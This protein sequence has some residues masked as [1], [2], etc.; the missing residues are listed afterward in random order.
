MPS[1]RPTIVP[2]VVHLVRQLKPRSILDVGIGFGKWG[3]LFREYSDIL[4]A[5]HDPSRYQKQ[6]WQVRIEGI[7]AHAPYVTPMHVFLYDRIYIGDAT[8]LIRSLSTYD[9]IFLGDVIE[10]LEK[11]VGM[12]LLR[13]ALEH[14]SKAVI[15]STPKY[16]TGQEDL[17]GN[18]FERH[19][20]LWTAADFRRA[21][22]ARVKT[23]GND[24]LLAV[25]PHPGVKIDLAMSQRPRHEE[26]SKMQLAR[27]E[28]GKLIPPGEQF[29]LA[30]EEHI[31][32]SLHLENA[33]P[34][35]EKDG[36]YWGPPENDR[37]AIDELE[38]MRKNGAG[39]ILFI[40]STFWWLDYYKQFALHL[41]SCFECLRDDDCLIAFRLHRKAAI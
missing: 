16:E 2:L 13:E 14:A 6:N 11:D 41:R 18:E 27:R 5:E 40:S 15:V 33:L 4:E 31:R 28:I 19:R 25:L 20:S 17:C 32:A 35:L 1:C 39:F 12:E 23:V 21:G 10:H 36:E 38:R 37:M 7:E 29:I 8:V 22:T 26:A 9:V 34:F 24:T 3:H 30:D